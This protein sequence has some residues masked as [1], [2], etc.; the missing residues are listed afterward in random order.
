V[1]VDT[2]AKQG[3]ISFL[4]ER[5]KKLLLSCRPGRYEQHIR[6]TNKSFLVLFFKEELLSW[7]LPF[8]RRPV[9]LN[10]VRDGASMQAFF[11]RVVWL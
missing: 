6:K 3:N 5:N 1:G 2:L 4:K 8:L 9:A 11:A 10:A 7:P